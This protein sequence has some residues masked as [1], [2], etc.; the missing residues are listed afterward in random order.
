MPN[1]NKSDRLAKKYES[2]GP[3]A[4]GA[5]SPNH[6]DFRPDAAAPAKKRWNADERAARTGDRQPSG[7][8]RPNWT[9]REDQASSTLDHKVLLIEQRDKRAVIEQL[10]SGAGRP[11]SS[12]AP[13][14]S[15]RSSPTSSTMPVFRQRRCTVT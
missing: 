14:R 5:H 9:P 12:P 1:F 15:Q 4:A 8:R 10:A 2:R 13:V 7:D 3:K 6:R 11:L